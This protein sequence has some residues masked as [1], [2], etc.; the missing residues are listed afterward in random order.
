MTNVYMQTHGCSANL[1]ESESMMGL[2]TKSGF[3][4]VDEMEYSDVNIIN[5][6]TVKGSSTPLMQVIKFTEQFPNKKID[7]HWLHNKRYHS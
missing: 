3:K 6:C 2:L 7:H 1:S 4:I 5:I